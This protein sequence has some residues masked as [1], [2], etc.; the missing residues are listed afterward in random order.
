MSG[1]VM[2]TRKP[3]ARTRESPRGFMRRSATRRPWSTWFEAFWAHP[4]RVFD[5]A[6]RAATP[7]FARMDPQVVDRVLREL[8][9]DL[10][11]GAWDTR[12]GEL[13]ALDSYDAG[14]RLVINP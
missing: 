6:A 7:S 8:R 10:D 13:R 9:C 14:L 3:G 5:V 1:S 12:H 11:N 4:E 2:A